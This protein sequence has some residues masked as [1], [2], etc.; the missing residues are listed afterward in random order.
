MNNEEQEELAQWGR[1]Q[2]RE[3]ARLRGEVAAACREGKIS[4]L[5]LALSLF[6]KP[7]STTQWDPQEAIRDTIARLRGEA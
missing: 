5:E 7:N 4:G 6:P 1:S 2:R 3:L